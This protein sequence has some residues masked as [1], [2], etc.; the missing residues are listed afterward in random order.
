MSTTRTQESAKH[1]N[2]SADPAPASAAA[3]PVPNAELTLRKAAFEIAIVTVGVLLALLMDEARQSRA[4]RVMA[5][6][7]R[8]AMRTEIEENRVRLAS[9]LML[10]HQAHQTLRENPAAGPALVEGA[11]N[12]QIAMTDTAWAMAVQT[13]AL[14]HMDKQERQSLAYVYASHEI[15]NQLLAEEM[16]RWTSLAIAGQDDTAVKMW[17]AYA[18]RIGISSCITSLRIESYRN[19]KLPT[20]RLQPLCQRYR[21][22]V[23]PAKLYRALGVVMPNTSWRPG[24]E[25]E[26]APLSE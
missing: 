14:R 6:E 1:E 3:G 11:A 26:S 13:G 8:T 22:S 24:R 10:L 12:F 23:P 25:Y 17:M 21:L 15:Y 19:P 4:D 7:V 2:L 20:D 16:N 18:Q 9:K 5:E